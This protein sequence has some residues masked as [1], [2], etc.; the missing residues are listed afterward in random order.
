MLYRA[1]FVK[2]V[3]LKN[4]EIACISKTA[5]PRDLGPCLKDSEGPIFGAGSS[6]R[7]FAPTSAV[8][9]VIAK[10]VSARRGEI[11]SRF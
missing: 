11:I 3:I 10:K 6:Q 7:H 4:I 2:P 5:D 8:F 1:F 9:A